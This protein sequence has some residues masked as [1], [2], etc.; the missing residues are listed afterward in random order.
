M[1]K[2]RPFELHLTMNNSSQAASLPCAL[3][4]TLKTDPYEEV[5]CK[6]F[7]PI[8]QLDTTLLPCEPLMFPHISRPSDHWLNE[9]QSKQDCITNFPSHLAYSIVLLT[10]LRLARYQIDLDQ[11]FGRGC[12]WTFRENSTRMSRLIETALLV[13]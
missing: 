4:V 7:H 11:E 10:P 8:A 12:R 9:E 3:G 5:D 13:F 1:P 2:G 6:R